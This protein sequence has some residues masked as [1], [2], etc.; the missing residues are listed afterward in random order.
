[1]AERINDV[2]EDK[3]CGREDKCVC[4][5]EVGWGVDV[6]QRVTVV[7]DDKCCVCVFGG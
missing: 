6:A 7:A 5:L 4:M 3:C 2:A 1:M